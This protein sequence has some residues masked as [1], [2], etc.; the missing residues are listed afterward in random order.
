MAADAGLAHLDLIHTGVLHF[1]PAR[2][3]LFDLGFA[4]R[5]Y[6]ADRSGRGAAGSATT[7]PV[8]NAGSDAGGS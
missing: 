5:R 1:G 7:E 2:F 4:D 8:G 6:L 3:G